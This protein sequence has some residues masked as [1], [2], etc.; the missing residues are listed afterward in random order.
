MVILFIIGIIQIASSSFVG[1]HDDRGVYSR[2]GWLFFIAAL[3]FS[4]D[5]I[6]IW[7]QGAFG[8]QPCSYQLLIIS[9]DVF[10]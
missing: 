10:K 2:V 7:M 3:L 9:D 5:K 1:G 6:I 4:V 8:G